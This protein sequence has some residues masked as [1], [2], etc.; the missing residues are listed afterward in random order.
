MARPAPLAMM[1]TE[2]SRPM[3]CRSLSRA[4]RSVVELLGRLELLPLGMAELGVAV[5]AHLGVERVDLALRLEDQRVDLGEV[6]VALG[7]AAVE[8]DEDL[9][10]AVQRVRV[11]ARRLGGGPRRVRDRPSTG[12]TWSLTMASGSRATSSMSTPPWADSIS[13]CFFADRSRVNGA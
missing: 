8:E 9:G 3:Y 13:R 12:S 6:A 4:R 7:V 10:D 11:D 2:P 5:E 1:P